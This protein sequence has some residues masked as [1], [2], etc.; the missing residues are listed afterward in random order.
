VA[1]RTGRK[2]GRARVGWPGERENGPG[3]WRIVIFQ[4]YSKIFNF[5]LNSFS[6]KIDFLCLKI[7]T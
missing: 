1:A 5:D 6:Q 7:F 4:N 2:Q 3:P